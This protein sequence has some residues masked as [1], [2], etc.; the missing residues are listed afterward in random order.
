MFGLAMSRRRRVHR[1]PV[2]HQHLVRQPA[3]AD[4]A[5]VGI[6]VG[7]TIAGILGFTLLRSGSSSPANGSEVASE[8]SSAAPVIV[9][10]DAA[11][12]LAPPA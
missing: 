4:A 11:A 5:K 8:P 7:S 2:R 12:V 9:S 6:L 10:A 1:R 3:L